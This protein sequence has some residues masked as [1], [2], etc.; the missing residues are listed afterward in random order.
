MLV[1]DQI[2]WYRHLYYS[3]LFTLSTLSVHI[4]KMG[5]KNAY[6][7]KAKNYQ[8]SCTFRLCSTKGKKKSC[9]LNYEMPYRDVTML[10]EKD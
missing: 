8:F 2:I 1:T 5:I 9:Q 10:G 3:K 4:N 6:F 7:L